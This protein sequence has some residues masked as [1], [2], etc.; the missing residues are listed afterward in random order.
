VPRDFS[1]EVPKSLENAF[2]V[3]DLRSFLA[4]TEDRLV[5]SLPE[6]IRTVIRRLK[7]RLK[8]RAA[9]SAEDRI[10][11]YLDLRGNPVLSDAG[12]SLWRLGLIPDFSEADCDRI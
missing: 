4:S 5:A 9:V 10:A 6:E 7:A 2:S 1:A 11:Y 8:G 12:R 3:F